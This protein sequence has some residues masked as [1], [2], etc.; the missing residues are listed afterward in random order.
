MNLALSAAR[1]KGMHVEDLVV[2]NIIPFYLRH[3][4]I[5]L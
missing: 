2:L 3:G 4:K 1:L 5:D